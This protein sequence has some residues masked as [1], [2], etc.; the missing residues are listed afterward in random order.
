MSASA[1]ALIGLHVL[2][3]PEKVGEERLRA[4][5]AA[6]GQ[7]GEPVPGVGFVF[8]MPSPRE[9]QLGEFELGVFV[10]EGRGGILADR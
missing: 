10:G 9:L 3:A 5:V 2:A 8:S 7:I 1:R 4:R 6:L